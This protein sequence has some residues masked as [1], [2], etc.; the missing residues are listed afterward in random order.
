MTLISCRKRHYRLFSV[1]VLGVVILTGNSLFAQNGPDDHGVAAWQAERAIEDYINRFI[2]AQKEFAQKKLPNNEFSVRVKIEG[3]TRG[4]DKE[5]GWTW[6]AQFTGAILPTDHYDKEQ[7]YAHGLLHIIHDK[8]KGVHVVVN[9][10]EGLWKMSEKTSRLYQVLPEKPGNWKEWVGSGD[11][12]KPSGEITPPLTS[13][14]PKPTKSKVTIDVDP[15]IIGLAK[16]I[17]ETTDPK[18]RQ[19]LS[20][21]YNEM[22][23]RK[24]QGK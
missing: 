4:Y 22:I 1:F 5:K 10:G 2:Y 24:T 9:N 15:E 21:E 6:V 12:P 14:P 11:L 20:L 13:N 17:R 8:N 7:G 3:L 19:R 23:I 16:R 18:E